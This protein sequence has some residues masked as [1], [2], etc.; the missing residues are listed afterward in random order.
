MQF[1]LSII[2]KYNLDWKILFL[3]ML[4]VLQDAQEE[5]KQ[6]LVEK[7]KKNKERLQRAAELRKRRIEEQKR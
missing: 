5:K 3:K 7:E 6:K 4:F 2:K 1:K